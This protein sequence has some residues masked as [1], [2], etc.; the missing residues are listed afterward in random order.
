MVDQERERG[1]TL[2]HRSVRA[3]VAMS[4][5]FLLVHPAWFGGWSWRKVAPLLREAG[6][7]A[8]TPT[9]TGLGERAH[10]ARPEIGL[11]THIDD[12]VA[13]IEQE[14]LS[15][16][17]LLGNSSSGMVITGVAG[18]VPERISRLIYLDAFVPEDG[19]SLLDM[20]PPDR[21][22]TFE[23]LVRDEGDGWLMPRFSPAPWERFMPEAWGIIG[24]DLAW[25]LARVRPTPFGHFTGAVNNTKAAT[26]QLRRAYIRC[27]EF[28]HP[29]F[30]RF[31][32]Q[33]QHQSGWQCFDLATSHLPQITAPRALADVLLQMA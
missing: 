15:D 12:V 22:V 6:H 27:R 20:L 21:R 19:Q 14:D 25:V 30:D 5:T 8:F 31:A 28:S 26:E 23:A 10:L 17:L 16:V 1:Y 11:D 7:E 3:G 13:V 4:S 32:Q 29:G 18:R 24:D 9:L 33:A 2:R